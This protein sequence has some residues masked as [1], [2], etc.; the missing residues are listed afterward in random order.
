MNSKTGGKNKIEIVRIAHNILTLHCREE[1][2][3]YLQICCGLLPNTCQNP[4]DH[5]AVIEMKTIETP[6]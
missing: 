6:W 3:Y 4:L 5:Q 2:N 1:L